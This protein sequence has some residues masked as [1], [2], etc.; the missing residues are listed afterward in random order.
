MP[1]QGS[2]FGDEVGVLSEDEP[3]SASRPDRIGPTAVT[4][5]PSREILTRATGFMDAYDF[6]LNPY[7]GCS[8]GCTYCYAA[9]FSRDIEKQN[10]W[11]NWVTVKENA[12]ALLKKRKPGFL[13]GK[14]IYMSSV[15]DPYQP[16]E[17]EVELTRQILKLMADHHKPKLVVQTRSPTVVRD[18]DLYRQIEE[19][20]GRVQI[21]MTVTTDDEGIRRTFE[22][23]CPSNPVRLKAIGEVQAAGLDTCI[24]M[25]PVL[26]VNDSHQFTESL[27]DTG[28]QNFIAQPFHFSRG[29]FLAGT[30][31]KAFALMAE[32]LGCSLKEFPRQY[33]ERYQEFFQHLKKEL[34]DRG[35]P[36]LGEGKDGF[37]P[38]F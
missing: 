23:S 16:V 26:L 9:F 21:N 24:T 36:E 18:V 34:R 14:R 31:D 4:Y 35:L 2:L 19:N 38:P 32:R 10:K 22:P 8:F 1:V 3:P 27:I 20:G 15:T 17:R 7:S 28:V 25:T 6:T 13:D 33:L 29:R 11:G 30:R 12:A 5:A 37:K